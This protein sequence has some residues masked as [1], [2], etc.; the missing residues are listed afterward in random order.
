MNKKTY[1]GEFDIDVISQALY[2][3]ALEH[4]WYTQDEMGQKTLS[5]SLQ[6]DGLNPSNEITVS[7]A[8]SISVV[9]IDEIVTGASD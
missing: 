6:H 8:D 3:A 1:T 9:A 2:E 5:Y 4:H 7:F